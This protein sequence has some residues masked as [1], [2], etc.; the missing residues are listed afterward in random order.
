MEKHIEEQEKAKKTIMV[1]DHMLSV[2][3]P[4]V[5]DPKML[6]AILENIF[7]AL[8][9]S[10]ASV[11]YLHRKYKMIPPFHD[12][13]E[14]KY[15]SFVTYIKPTYKIDLEYVRL[16]QD[17]KDILIERKSSP[18][19]FSR[20]DSFVICSDKYHMRRISTGQIKNFL[21]M[22]KKFIV[23]IDRIVNKDEKITG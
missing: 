23:E 7:I 3:F 14:S 2:T 16:I 19:E 11:L 20:K 17:I 21:N 1:A 18:M 15:N 4:L 22:T 9:S 6:V 8:S 5:K 13:F 10:V 12:T